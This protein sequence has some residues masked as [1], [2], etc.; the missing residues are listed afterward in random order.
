MQSFSPVPSFTW[1]I[2]FCHAPSLSLLCSLNM[3]SSSVLPPP[4]LIIP[5]SKWKRSH[6]LMHHLPPPSANLSPSFSHRFFPLSA[7]LYHSSQPRW[8]TKFLLQGNESTTS[9][10]ADGIAMHWCERR[11]GRQV[12]CAWKCVIDLGRWGASV[13]QNLD[14]PVTGRYCLSTT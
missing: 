4:S 5:Y 7:F 9:F 14:Q 12:T 10:A 8:Q 1:V 11:E 3:H 6:D 2:Q 13:D